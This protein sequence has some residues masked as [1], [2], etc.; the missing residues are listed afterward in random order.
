M[1]TLTKQLIN[2]LLSCVTIIFVDYAQGALVNP[3]VPVYSKGD[4]QS[5]ALLKP[6]VVYVEVNNSK[7]VIPNMPAYKTQDDL[8]ECR[9]FSLATIIQKF[10]CDKWKSDIPDCK[11]P[12]ADSAISYIGMMVYTNNR[13][14]A[15]SIEFNQK[16]ISGMYEIISNLAKS[17]NKLILESCKP[18]DKMVNNFST[19]GQV[20]L[21]KRDKFFS[22][23]KDL[24]E[25][26]KRN[27]EANIA[28]CPECLAEININIGLNA[29][30]S[31][32]KKALTKKNYNEFIYSLFFDS[33]KMESFPA[34]FSPRD[35]PDDKTFAQPSDIKNKVK[36]GLS[37]GKPVLFPAL[38]FEK[39]EDG[40]C[41]SVHSIVI[42]GYK[43][44]CH[45][46]EKNNC[47]ELFKVHNSWGASWQKANNDG[48]V[49]ADILVQ[50]VV[51]VKTDKGLKIASSSVLWLEP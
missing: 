42:A 29:D 41:A 50:N 13:D 2:I 9:A 26:R 47:R 37:K 5:F 10:T 11:N 28:D 6:D 16:N 51:R 31:N 46:V 32:L 7:I 20:G 15:K 12:P 14:N 4:D 21:D 36:E 8:G 33:C 27:T 49:D 39:A 44:S 45:P 17:G 24:Y 48:W 35:Y 25:S 34:S 19:T 30:L 1:Q 23:L 38:C 40:T 3:L 18:F 22:Y 43:K